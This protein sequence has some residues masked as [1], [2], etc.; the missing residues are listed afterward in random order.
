MVG[1]EDPMQMF[2]AGGEYL[3][4]RRRRASAAFLIITGAGATAVVALAVGLHPLAGAVVGIMIAPVAA[5]AY[6]RRR[7]VHKTI[8][9][10]TAVSGLLR[11]LPNDYFLLNDVVLPGH[12]GNVDHVVIGPCG[13]VVIETKNYT[14]DVE[15]YGNAWFVNGRRRRTVSNQVN[16]A[17]IAV[18]ET[19][20]RAHPELKDS[21]LR[22]VESVAVFTNPSSRVRIDHGGTTVARYSQLLDVIL[23]KAR[24]K[25]VSPAVAASLA[26]S[27]IE[28]SSSGGPTILPS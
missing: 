21:V 26:R 16:R 24:R 8:Q 15:S 6:R 3:A 10:E 23:A 25:K 20:G 12:P 13:V 4:A 11:S 17:A 27:L 28:G 9:G 19:L 14:G 22:F 7:R 1:G 18:R 5:N 2:R